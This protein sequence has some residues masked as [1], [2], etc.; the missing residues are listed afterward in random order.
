METHFYNDQGKAKGYNGYRWMEEWEI[1]SILIQFSV[2]K[3]KKSI[4]KKR[5]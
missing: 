4:W 3:T 5:K 1:G 2:V